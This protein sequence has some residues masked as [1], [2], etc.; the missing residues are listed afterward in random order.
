MPDTLNAGWFVYLLECK[1]GRIYTGIT[2]NVA[3]R[4]AK[5]CLGKGAK[6][7]R[8]NKPLRILAVKACRD[9]SEASKLEWQIKQL[10]PK[11]K[12]MVIADWR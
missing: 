7:T 11:K 4:F 3:A 10:T 6:Y 12:L 5:H 1:N 2:T 9:R 8:T